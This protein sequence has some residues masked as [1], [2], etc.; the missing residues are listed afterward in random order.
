MLKNLF[1]LGLLT[2]VTLSYAKEPSVAKESMGDAEAFKV[3][4]PTHEQEAARGVAGSKIKRHKKVEAKGDGAEAR[5]PSDSDSEVRY[6]Q[7]SE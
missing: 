6:W 2:W 5:E 7:Y 4:K 1:L 3:E